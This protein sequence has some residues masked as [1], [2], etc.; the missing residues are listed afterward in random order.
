MASHESGSRG[1][2]DRFHEVARLLWLQAQAI[3]V[4]QAF[5]A[6]GVQSLLLKGLSTSLWLWGDTTSRSYRDIDLLVAPAN[7]PAAEAVLRRLGYLDRG[8]GLSAVERLPHESQYL[9]PAGACVDLHRSIVGMR[10]PAEQLFERL[11]QEREELPP[12]LGSLNALNM[13]A[14]LVHCAVH[15]AAGGRH[16]GRAWI[17]LDRAVRGT[18]SGDWEAAAGLAA[19]LDCMDAFVAGLGLHPAAAGLLSDMRLPSTR[20]V[21]VLLRASGSSR[22]SR[23]A[24]Q[25]MSASPWQERRQIFTSQLLPSKAALELAYGPI[26]LS[27]GIAR[28]RLQHARHVAGLV[29]QVAAEL[30]RAYRARRR[31]TPLA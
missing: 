4:S 11:W 15:A 17:V 1:Q 7:W 31:R 10:L 21:E 2:A 13:R 9:G 25:L 29:P 26:I 16:D 3:R 14:R 8:A 28:A 30:F 12:S 19:E 20:N 5:A 22:G 27:K 18:P 24:Y 6:E 23:R